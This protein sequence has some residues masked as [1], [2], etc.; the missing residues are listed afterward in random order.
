VL[1]T[2]WEM[3]VVEIKFIDMI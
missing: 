2:C 3:I 1:K